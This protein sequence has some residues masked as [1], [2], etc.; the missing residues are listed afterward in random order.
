MIHQGE[1]RISLEGFGDHPSTMNS[2]EVVQERPAPSAPL[3]DMIFHV[4]LLGIHKGKNEHHCQALFTNAFRVKVR[5]ENKEMIFWSKRFMV[6]I[7]VSF[8]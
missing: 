2:A 5:W 4:L 7:T 6:K 8:Q 3:E 1:V